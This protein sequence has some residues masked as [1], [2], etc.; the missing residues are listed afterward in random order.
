[1]IITCMLGIITSCQKQ[2]SK[3]IISVQKPMVLIV[4]TEARLLDTA[5]FIGKRYMHFLITFDV[6]TG[7]SDVYFSQLPSGYESYVKITG[8]DTI[9]N[10]TPYRPLILTTLP[11]VILESDVYKISAH[12]TA[13]ITYFGMVVAHGRWTQFSMQV[14][15]FPYSLGQNDGIYESVIGLDSTSSGF[16]R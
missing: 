8:P 6:I 13:R 16:P 9:H 12:D 4:S 3:E 1:M 11:E 14:Y 5:A 10:Y 2:K 7:D 15:M